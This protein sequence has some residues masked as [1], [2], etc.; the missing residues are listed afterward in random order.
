MKIRQ[1]TIVKKEWVSLGYSPIRKPSAIL[2]GKN[3]TKFF[4]FDKERGYVKR[5]KSCK[6]SSKKYIEIF[7]YK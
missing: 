5:A 1:P 6:I 3:V 4:V 7:F 2:E